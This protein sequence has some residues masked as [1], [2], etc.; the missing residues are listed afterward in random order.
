MDPKLLALLET[1]PLQ[2]LPVVG[3]FQNYPLEKVFRAGDFLLLCGTSDYQWAYLC[4]DNPEE[5][6]EVLE[7]FNFT[8]PYFANV[9]DWM[10]PAITHLHGIDWKLT[11]HRYYLV[12]DR[13]IEAPSQEFKS[14][15]P[16][17]AKQVFELSAYKDYTSEGYIRDRLEKD[18]SIGI[19]LDGQ[20]V[21]W[22]LT[23]DDA[24]LG[25]LNVLPE[26]QGKGLGESILKAL[27]LKKREMNLPVFV[28]IE[29]HNIQSINLIK[30]LGFSFDRQVSWLKL[31]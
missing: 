20:L 12:F 28:N 19:W 4:G 17:M 31:I 29:P 13:T 7:E 30:K 8:S 2:S 6:F 16:S 11:T 22:G 26:W 18:I 23:H 3:F 5:L 15:E 9:E 27:I 1:M 25:F 10:M 24:S 21:G 14:L